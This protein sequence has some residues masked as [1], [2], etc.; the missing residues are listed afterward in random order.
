MSFFAYHPLFLNGTFSYFEVKTLTVDELEETE[1]VLLLTPE[2]FDA[3]DTRYAQ[4]EE[5]MID[6][7]GHMR[8]LMTVIH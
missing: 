6:W 8:T 4:Q 7:E 1:S 5:Y 2:H 3:H